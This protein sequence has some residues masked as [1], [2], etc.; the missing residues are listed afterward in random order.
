MTSAKVIINQ[1]SRRV[2]HVLLRELGLMNHEKSKQGHDK[3]V[4]GMKY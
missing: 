2:K 1:R 4:T 3:Q